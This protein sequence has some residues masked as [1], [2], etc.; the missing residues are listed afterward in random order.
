MRRIIAT[1]GRKIAIEPG[2]FAMAVMIV[3]L[4]ATGAR[5]ADAF[6]IVQSTVIGIRP[7]LSSRTFTV[8][9]GTLQCQKA[10]EFDE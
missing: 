7:T 9:E 10:V 5:A 3:A 4:C 1:I 8:T 6:I 2:R